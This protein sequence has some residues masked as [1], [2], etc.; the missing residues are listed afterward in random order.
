MPVTISLLDWAADPGAS[1]SPLPSVNDRRR[2]RQGFGLDDAL[3][4]WPVGLLPDAPLAA[5]LAARGFAFGRGVG[6]ELRGRPVERTQV[7]RAAADLLDEAA[8]LLGDA[9]NSD[10][11]DGQRWGLR[12]TA[13]DLR[14]SRPA[15]SLLLD[16]L[17]PHLPEPTVATPPAAALSFLAAFDG[18]AEVRRSHL[19]RD[20]AAAG[21]PGGLT[22]DRIRALA[23]ERWGDVVVVRGYEVHRPTRAS[24]TPPPVDKALAASVSGLVSIYGRE[25]VLAAL[26]AQSRPSRSTG[27]P[28]P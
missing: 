13:R 7:A 3:G 11:L 20:Y 27:A 18:R 17:R 21:Y 1:P 25:A 19:A 14:T 5:D 8:I 22:K 28:T 12:K 2:N 24:L 26:H 15:Q 23:A 16:L 10:E 6:Y 9:P 4:A